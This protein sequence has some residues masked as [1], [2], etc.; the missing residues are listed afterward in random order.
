VSRYPG[1]RGAGSRKPRFSAFLLTGGLVG[2]VVGFFLSAFGPGDGRYDASAVLGFLGV[3]CA[4]LGALAAGVIAVL[5][6]KRS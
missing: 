4:G 1:S 6:D 5:L 3:V 2:L